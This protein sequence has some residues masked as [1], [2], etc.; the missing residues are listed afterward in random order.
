MHVKNGIYFSLK[1]HGK[2]TQRAV[3]L[4][5]G[6]MPEIPDPVPES[7]PGT[8]C[9]PHPSILREHCLCLSNNPDDTEDFGMMINWNGVV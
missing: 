7:A 3:K 8:V 1:N 4:L 9:E 5:F 2:F 6:L